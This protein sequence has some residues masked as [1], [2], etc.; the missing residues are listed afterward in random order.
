MVELEATLRD[1]AETIPLVDAV[2]RC[3]NEKSSSLGKID[4]VIVNLIKTVLGKQHLEPYE[5]WVIGLRFFER[6]N[7]S[8]FRRSLM[9]HLAKWLR[10]E[11]KRVTAKEAF[12]L[13]RPREAVPA[14]NSVLETPDDDQRFVAMLVLV[15]SEAVGAPLAAELIATLRAMSEKEGGM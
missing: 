2:F 15:T 7:H 3:W 13:S 1:A 8:Y 4:Q 5:L 10:T 9:P 14:I 12:R 11:W 6:T